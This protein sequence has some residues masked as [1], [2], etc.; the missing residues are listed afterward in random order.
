MRMEWHWVGLRVWMTRTM[1]PS[2]DSALRGP[3]SGILLSTV[4]IREAAVDAGGSTL[5]TF[6]VNTGATGPRRWAACKKV[7]CRDAP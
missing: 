7:P 6:L 1:R 5:G 3:C 2:G 4:V